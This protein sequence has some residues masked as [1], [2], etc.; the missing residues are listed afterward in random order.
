MYLFDSVYI[1]YVNVFNCLYVKVMA[2][3]YRIAV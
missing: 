3:V 1:V 2:K